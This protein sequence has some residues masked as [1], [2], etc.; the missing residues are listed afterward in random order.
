MG[1]GVGLF[2]VALGAILT[3]A[4][5]ID[6][7]GLDLDV[8]GVILMVVGAIGLVLGLVFLGSRRRAAASNDDQ[9]R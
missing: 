8:V 7:S 2:L 6:A 5:E 4:V 3:F 9:Y 1:I